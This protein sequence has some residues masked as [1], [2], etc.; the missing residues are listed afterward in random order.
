[1]PLMKAVQI[2]HPGAELTLV[3]KDFEAM[4]SA[5]VRFW[6]VFDLCPADS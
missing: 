3:E 1:M 6:A 2:S 4:M 5:S